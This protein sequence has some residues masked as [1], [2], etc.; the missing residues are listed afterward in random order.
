MTTGSK[1]HRPTPAETEAVYDA[2]GLAQRRHA[3]RAGWPRPAAAAYRQILALRP[4]I[5]EVDNNLGNV[6]KD[7]GQLDEAAAQYGGSGS[8]AEPSSR[9]TTWATSCAQGKLDRPWHVIEQA[10]A[11]R[12]DLA[13]AYNNLGD[14]LGTRASSTKRRSNT[15]G[16]WLSSPAS[17]GPQ[18]PGQ[19]LAGAGQ[20]RS[21]RG[22]LSSKRSLSSPTFRSPQQSGQR[23]KDQGQ[24]DRPRPATTKR[25]LSGPTTPKRI[26]IARI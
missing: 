15:S 9:T 5:A 7:Q 2:C 12:P 23:L 17:S 6:L 3:S 22:T 4:E 10:I 16:R 19:H 24:L 8:Q 18:Q 11:L 26:T 25:S 1:S 21:G 13:E 14:V 20:A